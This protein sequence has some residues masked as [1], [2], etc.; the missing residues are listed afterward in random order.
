MNTRTGVTRRQFQM[1]YSFIMHGD[2]EGLPEA[3]T[4][5]SFFINTAKSLQRRNLLEHNE[6]GWQVTR[7]GRMIASFGKEAK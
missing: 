1:L 4:D 2:K 6:E 3:L 7:K 5:Y